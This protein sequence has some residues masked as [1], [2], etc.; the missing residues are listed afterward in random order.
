MTDRQRPK[1]I[2]LLTNQEYASRARKSEY[3]GC[4]E[5]SSRDYTLESKLNRA[6]FKEAVDLG[7]FEALVEPLF[8]VY[9]IGLFRGRAAYMVH[10]NGR[11]YAWT[12]EPEELME[13]CKG[14]LVEAD[15]APRGEGTTKTPCEEAS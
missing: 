11:V 2:D 8:P 9:H 12:D 4:V 5:D 7:P 15:C 1:P 6:A 14:T 10:Q 13:A 3:L